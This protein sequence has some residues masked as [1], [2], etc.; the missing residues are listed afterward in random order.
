MSTALPLSSPI[1]AVS[2]LVIRCVLPLRC[3]PGGEPNGMVEY[4]FASTLAPRASSSY[5]DV[6][7]TICVCVWH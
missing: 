1:H 7:E 2:P 5:F 3:G 4:G 6:R